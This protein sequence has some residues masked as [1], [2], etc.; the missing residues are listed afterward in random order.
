M[1]YATLS[2]LKSQLGITDTT[3]DDQL[4]MML[5]GVSD[6]IDTY[7]GRTWRGSV[8]VVDE[9][10]DLPTNSDGVF[11][12]QNMDVTAVDALKIG[13]P[14]GPSYQTLTPAV[15]Y[16]WNKYGRVVIPNFTTGFQ[17][18]TFGNY[19]YQTGPISSYGAILVSYHYGTV[20]APDQVVMACLDI[21]QTMYT[22]KGKNGLWEERVGDYIVR[23][24][25]PTEA[26]TR[27]QLGVLDGLRLRHV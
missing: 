4:T 6:F 20:T 18:S 17:T 5:K 12:L 19:G 15:D 16:L 10:H 22:H 13:T 2:Q 11:F 14:F 24:Q 27:D 7:T 23:Y 9:E 21:A 1:T 26:L 3:R 8:A 25:V